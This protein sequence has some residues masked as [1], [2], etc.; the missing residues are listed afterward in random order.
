MGGLTTEHASQDVADAIYNGF[1]AFALNLGN[2]QAS[3]STGAV[4]E[5]FDA[6]DSQGF[7]LFFSLDM[8]QLAGESA[9]TYLGFIKTFM[10]RGSY[11][12]VDN[13]PFLSTFNGHTLSNSQWQSDFRAQGISPF[14]VPDFDQSPNYT[15][16]FFGNYPDVQGAFSWESAW[17]ETSDKLYNVSD[18]TDQKVLTQARNKNKVYMMP[19]SPFQ[20]KNIDSSQYWYRI[21]ETNYAERIGQI[22]DLQPDYVELITWN[23]GGESHYVGNCW[24][25]AIPD[26]TAAGA[27]EHKLIDGFNHGAWQ[28]FLPQVIKAM[29]AGVTDPSKIYPASGTP[30]IG[31]MWYRSILTTASCSNSNQGKKPDGAAKAKDAINYAFLLPEGSAG[32]KVHVFSG[33]QEVAGSPFPAQ[34][35]LNHMSVP[36]LREGTVRVEVYDYT[37]TKIG[38][39]NETESMSV[40]SNGGAYCNYN[41]FVQAL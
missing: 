35:G 21:G 38:S 10:T 9:S 32:L 1:D 34:A 25:D 30:L 23:D 24:N 6:A 26:N 12:M 4:K 22:L 2:A 17:P 33:G 27:Q 39:S 8:N 29:K 31:A 13:K 40:S 5:L 20:Y 16:D 15:T 41:Y 14:F 36:G 7:K 18:S 28:R 19:W 11:Y 3:W 37:N